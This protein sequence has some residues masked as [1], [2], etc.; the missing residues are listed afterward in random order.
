VSSTLDAGPGTLRQALTDALPGDTITFDSSVFPPTSPKA[1]AVGSP[2]PALAKNNLTIDASAAGVILDGSFA[3]AYTNGLVVRADNCVIRGLTIQNFTSNGILVE[4]GASNNTVGGDRGIGTGPNGQGNLIVANSGSGIEIKGVGADYNS[5]RGNLIG[6]ERTGRFAQPNAHS[7]IAVYQGAQHNTLGGTISGFRNVISGNHDN[8]VWL[9]DA[10]TSQNSIIGN[11][12]GTTADGQAKVRNGLSGISLQNGANSNMIGGTATGAGN[13]ISGNKDYG[14]YMSNIGTT[15]N[16]VLGNTIGPNLQGNAV[17]GNDLDGIIITLGASNNNIGGNRSLGQGNLI[18]ANALDGVRIEGPSTAYNMVQGNYI[19]TDRAGAI[20]L[21]N[22]LHG[23]DITDGAH[24][25]TIGGKRSLD[26]GNLLSGDLNH[27]LVIH[28]DAHHNTAA[29]N[30]IGPD[31]TGTRS[32]GNHPNGGVD[33][34]EGAHDNLIGGPT[35]DEGNVISGNQTDG[36]AL[37]D[38]RSIGTERNTLEHNRIGLTLNGDRPLPNNGPGVANISGAAHSLIYSNTIAYNTGYGVWVAPCTGVS[39][40]NTITQS[41]IYSNTLGGILTSC[42]I[43]TPIITVTALGG[44]DTVVGATFGGAKVEIFSDDDGQ[45]RVYEG[46]TTANSS[47]QFIFNKLGGFAGPNITATST[48]TNGDTSAFSRPA[49]LLWTLLLYLN[50]D[51]DLGKAISNTFSPIAAAGPSQ[52]ANVLALV[53]GKSKSDT[54]LYDLTHGQAI[55][56]NGTPVITSS[57][58]RNM[59]DGRSLSDF[60]KWGRTYYPA[61]HTLL[62]IVDHGGGWAPSVGDSISNSLLHKNR[63]Q[64]GGSGLSWDFSDGYDYLDSQEVRAALDDVTAHGGKLDVVFYDVCLMGMLEVAYQIKDNA[65]YFVSSQNIGWAPDKSQNRYVQTIQRIGP[66]TTPSEMAQLLVD[67]YSKG[68]PSIWHPYTISAVDLG[69]IA[70]EVVPATD[71]LARVISQTITMTPAKLTNLTRAYTESQK[72]DYDADFQIE[73]LTDGFV[74]LYDF[75]GHVRQRFSAQ[76]D[77]S[78]RDA[79]SAVIAALD[80]AIV[81]NQRKSGYPWKFPTRYWNLDNAHGLSIFL[82]LGEDLEFVITPTQTLA[83]NPTPRTLRLREMYSCNELQF[84][85]TSPWKGLI[86]TYYRVASSPIPTS[87]H[88]MPI[89]G[90]SGILP[91]DKTPPQTTITMT[92]SLTFPFGQTI[93]IPWSATDALSDTNGN[94]IDG[95]GVVS[96]S[97]WYRTPSL[98]W[99]PVPNT[100]QTGTGGIFHATIPARCGVLLSVR[101][102][103]K[104]GNVEPPES[105]RNRANVLFRPCLVYLPIIRR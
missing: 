62:S 58:E 52:H 42:L 3:P 90:Q 41:S 75:A 76:N 26:Q 81:A 6:I 16:E 50:G 30:I 34:A 104:V 70:S 57:R 1:I 37:F 105:G 4:A 68:I 95:S 65:R 55:K 80:R 8:G 53:D 36:I 17:I 32:L 92:G 60:V 19:S 69:K 48:N 7:G 98:D 38:S 63:W 25:N 28:Y 91:V 9:S 100:K 31:A 94:S 14:I 96:A 86:D 5:L 79:A 15:L 67:S 102:V 11:Y 35:E 83:S 74:D 61:R 72:I 93:S 44:T 78:V 43:A 56:I 40:G 89:E 103:D 84:V 64:G 51:N 54:V 87:T 39:N 71:Q 85:C 18:S 12:I 2:L 23:V 27:G 97:L 45:G 10:G 29:G 13:L 82:P 59:G 47:G 77:Q 22:G 49:H 20:A 88:E 46:F 24:H 21:P 73:L 99:Q 33:I 101:A 66:R